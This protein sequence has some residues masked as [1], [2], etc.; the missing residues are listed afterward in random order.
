MGKY[1]IHFRVWQCCYS[2]YTNEGFK[3]PSRFLY[4]IL[5]PLLF[6]FPPLQRQMGHYNKF[7]SSEM[8]HHELLGKNRIHL[9][10]KRNFNFAHLLVYRREIIF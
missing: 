9:M 10:K 7:T 5:L 4:G 3:S 6:M 8:I 2:T 1:R